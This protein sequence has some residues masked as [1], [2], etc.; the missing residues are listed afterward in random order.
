MCWDWTRRGWRSSSVCSV[1]RPA[2]TRPTSGKLID[3]KDIQRETIVDIYRGNYREEG[4]KLVYTERNLVYSWEPNS[5][6]ENNIR[7]YTLLDFKMISRIFSIHFKII[8]LIFH[9][10]SY[11][12]INVKILVSNVWFGLGTTWRP[13]YRALFTSVLIA[14]KQGN[15]SKLSHSHAHKKVFFQF[16]K[17]IRKNIR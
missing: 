13:I 1:T 3:T 16:R 14:A 11:I 17:K 5:Y 7:A 12:S 8:L 6:N 2:D 4:G 9:K 10:Y 15:H